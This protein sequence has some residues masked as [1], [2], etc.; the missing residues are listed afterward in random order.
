MVTYGVFRKR[1]PGCS[2]R[3]ISSGTVS[4]NVAD[5]H[6]NIAD[7]LGGAIDGFLGLHRAE[8]AS[9]VV[10]HDLGARVL[11]AKPDIH[12]ITPYHEVGAVERP[13]DTESTDETDPRRREL[14]VR[15]VL[16]AGKEE[17]RASP[18]RQRTRRDAGAAYQAFGLSSSRAR[19]QREQQWIQM[20]EQLAHLT[21][22]PRGGGIVEHLLRRIEIMHH[23]QRLAVSLLEGHLRTC[24]WSPASSLVQTTARAGS[25]RCTRRRT[26]WLT[27]CGRTRNGSRLRYEHL[28]PREAEI[29]ERLR[30]PSPLEQL[31]LGPCVEHQAP[32]IERSCHDDLTLRRPSRGQLLA[33]S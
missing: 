28:P 16:R 23:H 11:K 14:G 7:A 19:A 26:P 33:A 21:G 1:L 15:S 30:R 17:K 9:G 18:T 8:G 22:A 10:P 32:A 3:H 4:C 13:G 2:G 24:P 29:R 31:E 12:G 5:Q 25:L 27:H 6:P 20:L